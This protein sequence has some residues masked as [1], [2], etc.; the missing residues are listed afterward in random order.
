MQTRVAFI[1]STF[2]APLGAIF[3]CIEVRSMSRCTSR[4]H[5]L[6]D[7]ARLSKTVNFQK[8]RF[9]LPSRALG[10]AK[11]QI[12]TNQIVPTKEFFTSAAVQDGGVKR[13]RKIETH[14]RAVAK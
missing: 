9:F 4:V 2:A 3:S 10:N 5:T 6:L 11:K 1:S 14:Q 13:G 12:K 8:S 7:E